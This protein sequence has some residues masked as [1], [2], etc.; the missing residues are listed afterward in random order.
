MKQI[1]KAIVIYTR[2][3]NSICRPSYCH[4][5]SFVFPS[6]SKR[7]NVPMEKYPEI[8]VN[9]RENTGDTSLRPHRKPQLTLKRL[10]CWRQRQDHS[11]NR[12]NGYTR[13]PQHDKPNHNGVE[14][15]PCIKIHVWFYITLHIIICCF[16][17]ISL[18]IIMVYLLIIMISLLE[19][20]A[21]S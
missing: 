13:N 21:V 1:T 12:S 3:Q 20:E 18:L 9:I 10:T 4:F 16:G 7:R 8:V 5:K 14:D 11:K 19:I 15:L 17:Q 2:F 6:W